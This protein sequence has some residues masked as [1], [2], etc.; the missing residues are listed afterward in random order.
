MAT[1]S[2][3]R[4]RAVFKALSAFAAT[5]HPVPKYVD[6]AETHTIARILIQ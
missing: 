5:N 3:Q 4:Q 6:I 1:G 2:S